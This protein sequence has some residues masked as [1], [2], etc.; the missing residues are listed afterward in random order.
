MSNGPSSPSSPPSVA[1]G[2]TAAPHPRQRLQ[3]SSGD[4]RASLPTV[5]AV[6]Q[7]LSPHEDFYHWVL[8]LTWRA[9]FGWMA[10][11]YLLTNALF[12][13]AFMAVPGCVA[14]VHGFTDCF[15]FSV[16]TFATIGY[17]VMA[18][19]S[20]YAHVIVSFEAL[21][22]IVATAM[23]TGIT[24]ARLARPTAKVL[25]SQNAVVAAR[26]GVPN[27]QFR[28]AN[29]RRNQIAEAQL[30]VMILLTE[31][32]KEG[33]TMRRPTTLKLVRDRNPMFLLTWTAMHPIDSESPF[34]GGEPAMAKLR[35]MKAEIFLTLTGLDETLAQT[36]HTRYRYRLEDIVQNARFAD[37]LSMRPDGTR[38]IDFDKFHE[39]E[40]L[41]E[42]KGA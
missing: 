39:I 42:G 33:E 29:W 36:I 5:K 30:S 40:M 16:E 8:T 25:F 28:M 1:G 6:G 4:A 12:A 2:A 14:N 17:G 15:F 37:I 27:L 13:L 3:V 41:D 11:A 31:V 34:F 24:F 38:I 7:K 21:A 18:P 9:F 10:I 26:D 35:E 20:T 19:Q 22:G 32:T 23:I